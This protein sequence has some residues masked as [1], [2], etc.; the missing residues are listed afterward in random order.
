MRQSEVVLAGGAWFVVPCRG[1][2][3]PQHT[4][5]GHR[6]QGGCG[7]RPCNCRTVAQL[8]YRFRA[9]RSVT[10]CLGRSKSATHASCSQATCA[11]QSP[12]ADAIYLR[13]CRRHYCSFTSWFQEYIET[14]AQLAARS[15]TSG[16][17]S[18]LTSADTVVST[19]S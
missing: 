4:V 7:L 2:C 1:V 18:T 3:P 5:L 8:F 12:L 10:A 6:V 11:G 15:S 13:Q 14:R 16:R 9:M 19:G 17:T